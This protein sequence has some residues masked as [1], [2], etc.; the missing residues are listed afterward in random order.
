MPATES[1]A[2]QQP[3]VPDD[4][5]VTWDSLVQQAQLALDQMQANHARLMSRFDR[6][7]LRF[8]QSERNDGLGLYNKYCGAHE[9]LRAPCAI[10][11]QGTALLEANDHPPLA[12]LPPLTKHWILHEASPRELRQWLEFY[13]LP[14]RGSNRKQRADALCHHMSIYVH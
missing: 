2:L 11:A 9:P 14:C 6:L 4:M 8:Q 13:G 12:K 10:N 3:S 1:K 7:D 5:A